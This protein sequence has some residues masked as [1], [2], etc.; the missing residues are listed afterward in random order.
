MLTA[1]AL[2]LDVK[3]LVADE[4][5]SMLD[6][7]TRAGLL[8]SLKRAGLAS[9]FITHGLSPGH[10][11]GDRTVMLRGGAVVRWATRWRCSAIRSIPADGIC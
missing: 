6:A 1:R 5:I 3:L 2:F 10:Y 9:L 7:P 8:V 4:I 11:V